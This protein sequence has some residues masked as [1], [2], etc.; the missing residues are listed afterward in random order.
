MLLHRP[1]DFRWMSR[2][3]GRSGRSRPTGGSVSVHVSAW[4]DARDHFGDGG[5][6]VHQPRP[7][8]DTIVVPWYENSRGDGAPHQFSLPEVANRFTVMSSQR[9]PNIGSLLGHHPLLRTCQTRFLRFRCAPQSGVWHLAR[10]PWSFFTT[11]SEGYGR[12]GSTFTGEAELLCDLS[13]G[14]LRAILAFAI[15]T[16]QCGISDKPCGMGCK[17]VGRSETEY[18]H[19]PWE[20]S[21]SRSS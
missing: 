11:S 14:F 9:I 21:V 18:M 7:K 6:D 17:L 13:L 12:V 8:G 4:S 10:L 20:A 3:S 19:G 5:T 15:G 1:C 16:I 2:G